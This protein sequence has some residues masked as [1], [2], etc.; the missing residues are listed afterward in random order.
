MYSLLLAAAGRLPYALL[1][2]PV[3]SYAT[4][5]LLISARL[6][7]GCLLLLV[8]RAVCKLLLLRLL[9]PLLL[10]PVVLTRKDLNPSRIYRTEIPIKFLTYAAIGFTAT[11]TAPQLFQTLGV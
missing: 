2:S 10:D 7:L 1:Q 5:L 8:T 6:L 11:W 4:L 3:S 9:P